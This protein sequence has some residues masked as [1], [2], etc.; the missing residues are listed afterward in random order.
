VTRYRFRWTC[1]YMGCVEYEVLGDGPQYK[2]EI[3]RSTS[4]YERSVFNGTED[5]WQ[6]DVLGALGGLRRYHMP[7]ESIPD[8][9]VDAFN[10]WRAAEH[11][12]RMRE[13]RSQPERYGEI[14]EDDPVFAPPPPVHA[15]V[16]APG[17]GWT[18]TYAGQVRGSPFAAQTTA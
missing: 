18:T 7:T 2:V 3:R 1:A 8:P 12:A 9:V 15:L 17:E 4:E 11:S 13:L 14:A 6:R 10:D 16:Y 5:E